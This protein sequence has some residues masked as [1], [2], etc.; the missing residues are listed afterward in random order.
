MI[1][2]GSAEAVDLEARQALW[3]AIRYAGSRLASQCA[4]YLSKRLVAEEGLSNLIAPSDVPTWRLVEALSLLM[5][6]A[7]ADTVSCK[8][9]PNIMGQT[10]PLSF[11]AEGQDLFLW[12]QPSIKSQESS[13]IGRPDL[14]ITKSAAPPSSKTILHV[15]ECKCR[16]R[17]GAQ[18]IRTELGK[19]I[20]LKVSSYLI[21]SFKTPKPNVVEGARRLGLDIKALELDGPRRKELIGQPENLAAHVGNTIEIVRKGARFSQALTKI[22][23]DISHK[24]LLT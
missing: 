20:D 11:S 9:V 7:K 17:L 18:D 19:A 3:N 13:L 22:G 15:I 5:I 6:L 8:A 2:K 21:W 23:E 14:V 24:M 1:K 10:G 16:Q 12:A 4:I